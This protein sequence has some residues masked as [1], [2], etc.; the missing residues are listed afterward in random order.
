MNED[1]RTLLAEA[2]VASDREI[3]ISSVI[4]RGN[5]L[6]TRRR[7]A[8]VAAA[9][10]PVL[11]LVVVLG[12]MRTSAGRDTESSVATR[13]EEPE[14]AEGEAGPDSGGETENPSAS[15][16]AGDSPVSGVAPLKPGAQDA[17]GAQG[18]E[19][20]LV[21]PRGDTAKDNPWAVPGSTRHPEPALDVVTAS[22]SQA[23]DQLRFVIEV[24]DLDDGPPPGSDGADYSF[25]FGRYLD[26]ESK[27]PLN[28]LLMQRFNDVEMVR[29]TTGEGGPERCEGCRV[30]FDSRR[31][32]VVATVPIAALGPS[33]NEATRTIVLDEI[34]VGTTWVHT[35][36]SR[37][38][39]NEEDGGG[40][41]WP[42]AAAGGD[43]AAGDG[44]FHVRFGD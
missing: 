10:L 1:T 14:A 21:D 6:R 33:T 40:R 22:I 9:A 15:V 39:F 24:D 5:Q 3:D 12:A 36:N 11:L 43:G 2:N 18:K 42:T 19:F 4:R 29:L 34:S 7:G 31:D 27:M 8:L 17:A 26:S 25:E 23:G 13:G 30:L 28:G 37:G 38:D 41:R 16:P 44:K 35:R 20:T 32:E